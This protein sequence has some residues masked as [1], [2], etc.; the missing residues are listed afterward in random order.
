MNFFMDATPAVAEIA[1]RILRIY[2]LSYLILPFN[3]FA[4]YYFQA[5]MKPNVSL[6]A[7]IARGLAVSG[8]AIMLLPVFLG[9]DSIWY[10]MLITE[11]IMAVFGFYYMARCNVESL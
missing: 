4:T 9:P 1:P 8:A 7:S 5:M 6:V 3:I 2:G 10:A 11:V